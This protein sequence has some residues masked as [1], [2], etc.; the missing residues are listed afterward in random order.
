MN[1]KTFLLI[2]ILVVASSFTLRKKNAGFPPGTVQVNDTLFFDKTEITNFNWLEY[3]HWK[4][5]E[6]GM[7]SVEYQASLPDT[8]VWRL[9][10]GNN[11][12]LANIYLRHP[13]YQEYPVVGISYEQA[14]DF[15]HWRSDRVNTMLMIQEGK[16][17]RED[18]N[19]ST[20]IEEKITY[21]LPT[22]KEWEAMALLGFSEHSKKAIKAEKTNSKLYTISSFTSDSINQDVC[23]PVNSHFE[24]ILGMKHLKGNVAEMIS[25]KGICKGGSWNDRIE[26]CHSHIDMPY[27]KPSATVGFRCVAVKGNSN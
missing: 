4:K 6:F 23:S 7:T 12:M 5:A 1:R 17:N 15:C 2:A 20:V 13:A 14:L 9:V 3:M 16:L 19:K 10:N 24:N 26:N 21:R 11:E 25:E 8:T 18:L 27:D 22:K